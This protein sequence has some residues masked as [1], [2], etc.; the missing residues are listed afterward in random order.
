MANRH[1][2]LKRQIRRYLGEAQPLSGELV[3]FIHAVDEAYHQFDADR[4]MLE[5]SLELSSQ[6]L[7][8]ANSEMR[9]LFRAIP[10]LFFRLDQDGTI[11]DCRAGAPSDLYL[12]SADLVGRRI[13]DIPSK[14]AAAKFEEALAKVRE[15]RTMVSI[16]Y[17]L[18]LKGERQHYE[19][20]ILP[21]LDNQVIAIIRNVTERNRI[22][23]ERLKISKLDSVSVLAGGIAHDF[24]NIL[25]AIIGNLSIAKENTQPAD[26]TYQIISDVEAAAHRAKKL[27]KQLLTFSSGGMPVR[28]VKAIGA[29][30]RESASFALS[31]S[32]VSCSFSIGEG[33][34]PIYA[35]AGQIGQ[36]IDNLVINAKQA[37]PGGGTIRIAAENVVVDEHDAAS[38]IP[39]TPG[40]YV[41]IVV[42]DHG[43]GI[44]EEHLSKIFDPYFTTK[45]TGT[46]LGL[47]TAYSIVKKHDGH[48]AV[49]SEPGTGTVFS[50]FLPAALERPAKMT[51]RG[52]LTK[53]RGRILIMDDQESVR[54]ATGKMLEH[55]GYSVE[56]AECGEDAIVAYVK[57]MEAGCPFRAIIMD[58][59]VP[60][61]MGG[62]EAMKKLLDQ[63]PHV[64]AIV[65]SGYLEE[66]IMADFKKHGFSAILAKPYDIHE[67]A[68]VLHGVLA[69]AP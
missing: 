8:Q 28:K 50:L 16:E 14:E 66:A 34:H 59:T 55:L 1:S 32:N 44:P 67:L 19:A 57:A 2:L 63:D 13:H 51:Q 54:T 30:L 4:A 46:G 12:F 61:R 38:G 60:G 25:A 17:S 68:V 21:L 31:G 15:S 64:K 45:K 56:L 33:L 48:I 10:D 62:K 36:V 52:T 6:E 5:R 41:K 49:R 24:N 35:D 18:D 39:I 26:P 40:K 37:M 43:E 58:A 9:T 47:A 29:L 23:E 65:S 53:G 69:G 20:R 7:L 3:R 11:L 27:V 42:E 22:E